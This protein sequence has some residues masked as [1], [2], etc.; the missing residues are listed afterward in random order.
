V[1]RERRR[2]GVPGDQGPGDRKSQIESEG[3]RFHQG[4]HGNH[5]RKAGRARRQH[6]G[7]S[8]CR[9]HPEVDETRDERYGGKAVEV[10]RIATASGTAS[11]PA[12]APSQFPTAPTGSQAI[13]RLSIA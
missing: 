10:D 5:R 6:E 7:E 1:E 13:I 8:G 9:A 4:P 2:I 3:S 11:G 12:P